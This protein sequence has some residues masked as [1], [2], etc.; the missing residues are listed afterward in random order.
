MNCSESHRKAYN[1]SEESQKCPRTPPPRRIPLTQS[2]FRPLP[3]HKFFWVSTGSEMSNGSYR[4]SP[5]R[6]S[7]LRGLIHSFDFEAV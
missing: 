4:D 3:P 7:V 6:P 2:L 1:W 5:L